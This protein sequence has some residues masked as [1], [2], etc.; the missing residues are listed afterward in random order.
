[1]GKRS[2]KQI[3]QNGRPGGLPSTYCESRDEASLDT[4]RLII[5]K[6]GS[7][8]YKTFPDYV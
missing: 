8:L 3:S 2:L 4:T 5:P 7:Q 6:D 1:M